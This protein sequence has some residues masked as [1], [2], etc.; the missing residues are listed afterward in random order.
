MAHEVHALDID[1]DAAIEN[2]FIAFKDVSLMNITE[3]GKEMQL[4]FFNTN[5]GKYRTQVH[6]YFDSQTR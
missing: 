5:K 4:S 3:K 6:F 1:T 2:G